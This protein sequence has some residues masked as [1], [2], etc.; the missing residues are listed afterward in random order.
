MERIVH[1]GIQGVFFSEE[2]WTEIYAII[3]TNNTLLNEL[4][5]EK[6]VR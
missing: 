2:D 3:Q 4:R 1:K 6:N 5:R